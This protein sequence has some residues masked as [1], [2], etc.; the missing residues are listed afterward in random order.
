MSG[1]GWR[2]RSEGSLRL[3]DD[4]KDRFGRAADRHIGNRMQ[5]RG[6]R[7][8]E[9]IADGRGRHADRAAIIYETIVMM[10]GLAA[11][12]EGNRRNQE[13]TLTTADGVDVTEG[14]R[15]VQ[16]KRDQRQ[17]RTKLDTVTKQTHH[18]ASK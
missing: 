6:R 1:D 3:L 7:R 9:R 17:P 2:A 5:Q 8:S 15:K 16:R 14:Q 18:D 10:A 12:G 4:G 11:I 13:I